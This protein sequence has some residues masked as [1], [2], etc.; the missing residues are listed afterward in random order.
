MSRLL[1][2]WRLLNLPCDG[3]TR[4]A[5]ESLDRDLG[6]FWSGSRCGRTCSTAGPADAI[7]Q[8]IT[9]LQARLRRLAK[10]AS[11]PTSPLPGPGPPG[12]C[13][14]AVSS[15]RSRAILSDRELVF[16]E[17]LSGI[18]HGERLTYSSPGIRRA[19]FGQPR[20]GS[21]RGGDRTVP[22]G[23]RAGQA[24]DSPSSRAGAVC[25]FFEITSRNDPRSTTHQ[26]QTACDCDSGARPAANCPQANSTDPG[27]GRARLPRARRG[28]RPAR[29]RHSRQRRKT[30]STSRATTRPATRSSRS[31][32]TTPMA[33]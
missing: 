30:S 16:H 28:W 6:R 25:L 32:A 19:A 3:M 21:V 20:P 5:S 27:C 13:A 18:G 12:R 29:R 15:A 26:C 11:K 31:T 2:I 33:A 23:S 10:A 1:R 17:S 14:P 8:Q 22:L 24:H 7:V 9:T 4:L